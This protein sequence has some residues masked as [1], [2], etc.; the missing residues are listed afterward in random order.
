MPAVE[1]A[2]F[3]QLR[4]ELGRA[5]GELEQANA[6]LERERAARVQAE[7]I[8]ERLERLQDLSHAIESLSLHALLKELAV[9]LRALLDAG[10]TEVEITQGELSTLRYHADSDGVRR[11]GPDAACPRP[12]TEA[13][14]LIDP[15]RVGVLRVGLAGTR[16]ASVSERALLRDAADRA[17]RGI[18]RALRQ[19]REHAIAVE[20]QRGLLPKSLPTLRRVTLAARYEAAGPEAAVGGDWYDAFELPRERLGIVLGDVAGRS[21]PAASAMGRL[22][23]VTTAFALGDEGG[24]STGEVLT[25]LSRYAG[26][27]VEETMFTVLYALLDPQRGT[28]HWSGAGHLP[29]LLRTS[30]RGCRYLKGGGRLVGLQDEDYPTLVEDISQGDVLVLYT[31]GLVERRGESLDVGLKRL[32]QA[33]EAGPVEPQALLDHLFDE[34]QAAGEGLS[35]DVTALVAR[36]D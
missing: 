3:D 32:A 10:W 14:V 6:E 1:R 8:S 33:V 29:P 7:A 26:S 2:D 25:R 5:Q 28:L 30:G 22:R 11:L 31:D 16:S 35:D 13:P 19:E 12:H 34:R 17:G 15:T 20:L 23:S 21:I 27:S 24:R 4:A 36:V 18:R 9:R